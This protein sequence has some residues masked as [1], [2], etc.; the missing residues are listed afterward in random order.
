MIYIDL[1]S[2]LEYPISDNRTKRGEK[3]WEDLMGKI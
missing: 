2:P 1:F 3:I